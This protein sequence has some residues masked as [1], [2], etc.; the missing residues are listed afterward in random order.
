MSADPVLPTP[1]A[2]RTPPL[3]SAPRRKLLGSSAEG[4]AT[5]LRVSRL[6]SERSSCWGPGATH[7]PQMAVR[8]MSLP[9]ARGGLRRRTRG[10]SR[11]P[12]LRGGGAPCAPGRGDLSLSPPPPRSPEHP[13][14]RPPPDLRPRRPPRRAAGPPRGRLT[15]AGPRLAAQGSGRAPP[16]PHRRRP[17]ARPSPRRGG[18][19]AP[20]GRD[21]AARAAVRAGRVPPASPRRRAAPA[22]DYFSC[23][24]GTTSAEA[25]ALAARTAWRRRR[26]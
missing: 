21:S 1:V 4:S 14:A 6:R 20:R 8:E 2:S 26:A 10:A 24:G 22:G 19:A 16:R 25:S 5:A 15:M 23:R 7:W 13:P 17:R 11:T 9:R 18:F 12:V 3:P